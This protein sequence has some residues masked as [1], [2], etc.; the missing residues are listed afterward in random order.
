M[1]LTEI[2]EE[3]ETRTS[4]LVLMMTDAE[5][6]EKYGLPEDGIKG[7]MLNHLGKPVCPPTVK[8]VVE[9]DGVPY[10]FHAKN[11]KHIENLFLDR[12]RRINA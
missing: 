4:S 5:I 11:P 9:K 8:M 6:T 12:S 3:F 2:I 1:T 7:L 10:I